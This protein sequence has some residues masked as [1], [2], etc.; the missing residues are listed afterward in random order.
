MTLTQW[1]LYL[2]KDN[3]LRI[4]TKDVKTQFE[5]ANVQ[6]Y[7]LRVQQARSLKAIDKVLV[8]FQQ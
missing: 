6:P 2:A 4:V 7:V 8:D 3:A 5:A 1:T